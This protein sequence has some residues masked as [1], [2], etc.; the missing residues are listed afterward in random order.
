MSTANGLLRHFS[1]FR[2]IIIGPG[3]PDNR[4]YDARLTISAASRSDRLCEKPTKR[5]RRQ[6]GLK[7]RDRRGHRSHWCQQ[8]TEPH[9][10]D[11]TRRGRA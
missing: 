11:F 6:P 9:Q 1:D 2:H 3:I 4:R 5:K 7:L 10:I 8:G